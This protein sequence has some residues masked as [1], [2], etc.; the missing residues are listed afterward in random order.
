MS[1][2]KRYKK[3]ASLTIELSLLMPGII[4]VLILIIYTGYYFHD[5]CIIENAICASLLRTSERLD[6]SYTDSEIE[7]TAID[8]FEDEIRSRL[9]GKWEMEKS[10]TTTREEIG[11]T[12]NG[13]MDNLFGLLS[14][15]LSKYV[16]TIHLSESSYTINGPDYI[17]KELYE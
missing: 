2:N 12:I 1:A 16:F 7:Y 10:V 15:L 8:I 5:K 11:L 4:A 9:I 6:G 17:T 13:R 14:P 3:R